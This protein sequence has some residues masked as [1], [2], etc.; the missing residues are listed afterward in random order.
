MQTNNEIIDGLIDKI[1]AL[2]AGSDVKTEIKHNLK[3]LIQASFSQLD[4][5]SKEE[6]DAQVAVLERTRIQLDQL[7]KQLAA[8]HEHPIKSN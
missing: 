5:V 4:M 1:T 6:F 2:T 3:A 7:E 8:L